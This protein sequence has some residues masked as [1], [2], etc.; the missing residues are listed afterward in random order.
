MSFA[1]IPHKAPEFVS[2]MV[3][4]VS[5]VPDRSASGGALQFPAVQALGWVA[6]RTSI[7]VTARRVEDLLRYAVLRVEHGG[8]DLVDDPG[9]RPTGKLLACMPQL[10]SGHR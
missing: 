7:S 6:G 9:D 1:R 4:R 10:I 5:L 2:G 8:A 3:A